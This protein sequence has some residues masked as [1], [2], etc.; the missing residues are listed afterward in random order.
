MSHDTA[1]QDGLG[2]KV[3][4]T[5]SIATGLRV[6]HSCVLHTQR[7]F[8]LEPSRSQAMTMS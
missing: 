1:Y 3:S 4:I 8:T 7:V 5:A 2:F 6:M